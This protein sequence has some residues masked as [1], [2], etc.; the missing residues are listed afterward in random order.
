[1]SFTHTTGSTGDARC[2]IRAPRYGSPDFG[3]DGIPKSA[4]G[5]HPACPTCLKANRAFIE[6]HDK[7]YGAGPWEHK[8]VAPGGSVGI[9]F[10]A[11]PTGHPEES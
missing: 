11:R 2:G 10:S 9:H 1:M 8:F 5:E 7:E 6:L 4:S 3:Q